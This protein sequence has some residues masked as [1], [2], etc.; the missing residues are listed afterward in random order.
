MINAILKTHLQT[1][2]IPE[3]FAAGECRCI[4]LINLYP[5]GECLCTMAH[6]MYL[7]RT[8]Q[9]AKFSN[10]NILF[11]FF[12]GYFFTLECFNKPLISTVAF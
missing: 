9:L 10:C 7:I 3:S 2:L 6:K 1:V 5:H 11:H 12:H 4:T 8:S